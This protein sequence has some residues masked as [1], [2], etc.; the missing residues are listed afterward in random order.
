MTWD[1]FLESVAND[2]TGHVDKRDIT[3]APA[4]SEHGEGDSTPTVVR[5]EPKSGR[6]GQGKEHP[7]VNDAVVE[8]IISP[9]L[10]TKK[11]TSAK[12]AASKHVQV[13]MIITVWEL[14][15]ERFYSLTFTSPDYSPTS[16][17]SM[18]GKAKQLRQGSGS[19]RL[20]ATTGS[21]PRSRPSSVASSRSSINESP[22]SSALNSPI[23]AVMSASP[24][25]PLGPPQRH[26]SMNSTPSSLQ[27]IITM[28]DYLLDNTNVPILA[29]WKDESVAVPNKGKF[30]YD[31]TKQGGTY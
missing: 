22:R 20:S 21:T 17:P 10:A 25:P 11:F 1:S 4:G 24:F 8:V 29:M 16:V 13:K 12:E 30:C 14:D 7:V 6:L 3:S 2:V 31:G 19:T 26:S 5:A 27:K 18:R 9:H 23:T 15:D 28:K